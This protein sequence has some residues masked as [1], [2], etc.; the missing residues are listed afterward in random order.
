MAVF[1]NEQKCSDSGRRI[2]LHN[3]GCHAMQNDP[4]HSSE[5]PAERDL[6]GTREFIGKAPRA[7]ARPERGTRLQRDV[8]AGANHRRERELSAHPRVEGLGAF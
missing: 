3:C 1:D 7:S 6:T 8:H 5:A 2:Q 4:R